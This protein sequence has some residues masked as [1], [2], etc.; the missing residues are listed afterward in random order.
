[1]DVQQILEWCAKRL[2]ELRSE[3]ARDDGGAASVSD[4]FEM[5]GKIAAFEEMEA[6]LR[7]HAPPPRRAFLQI[8]PPVPVSSNECP[9]FLARVTEADVAL[10]ADPHWME[11]PDRGLGP[12]TGKL[13]SVCREP[14][15]RS[16][17]GDVCK[18]GHGGADPLDE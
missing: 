15:Y 4:I 11:G 7:E 8:G 17:G 10:A 12:P 18:N 13:C 9:E 5:D 16:H 3:R 2:V 1:M 6:H 14:Q